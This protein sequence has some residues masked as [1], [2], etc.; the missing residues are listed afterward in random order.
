[1]SESFKQI[2]LDISINDADIE[3]LYREY[4]EETV[5]KAEQ[6]TRKYAALVQREAREII[7]KEGHID[8]SRLVNSILIMVQ[9]NSEGIL[10]RTYTDLK[11]AGYIH[12]GTKHVSEDNLVPHF[13]SFKTAP[14]LLAWG[15]RKKVIVKEGKEWYLKN[16][17]G[18]KYKIDTQ[19]GGLMLQQKALKFLDIPFEK[20]EPMFIR[21]MEGLLDGD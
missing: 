9:G 5:R 3:E 14:S 11:H 20:Y 1:M 10:G 7:A 17:D 12:D 15:K 16:K 6:I 4:G 13:V 2:E 18:K 21:E 19:N 8:T